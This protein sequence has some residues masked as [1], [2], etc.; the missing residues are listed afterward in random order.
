MVDL[1]AVCARRYVSAPELTAEKL[2]PMTLAAGGGPLT[3]TVYNTNDRVRVGAGGRFEVDAAPLR[4]RVWD[5]A[6]SAACVV[7]GWIACPKHHL[8]LRG[9]LFGCVRAHPPKESHRAPRACRGV[10][11]ALVLRRLL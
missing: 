7:A 11:R 5:N 4:S 3:V 8:S 9:R 1:R 6:I 10:P 2:F